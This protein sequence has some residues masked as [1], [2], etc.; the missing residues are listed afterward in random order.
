MA[1]TVGN[2]YENLANAIIVKACE[3]YRAALRGLKRNPSDRGH[4]DDALQLERFFHSAW[5]QALTTVD[6]DFLIRKIREEIKNGR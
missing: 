1:K 2:P 5:Y 6:G 3:D 4:M